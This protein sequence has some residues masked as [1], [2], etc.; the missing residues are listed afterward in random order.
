MEYGFAEESITL[1]MSSIFASL[2]TEGQRRSITEF[3]NEVV[4]NY[5]LGVSALECVNLEFNATFKVTSSSNDCFALRININ[6][7]RSK[8]NLAAEVEFVRYL[9]AHSDIEL[10]NPVARSSGEFF[11]SRFHGDS[12][13]SLNYVLYTW[14]NGEPIGSEPNLDQVR[15]LGVTMAKMH[16]ATEQFQLSPSSSLEVLRDPLWG[17]KDNLTNV[18]SPLDAADKEKFSKTLS[19]I[20]STLAD[21]YSSGTPQ[22][23][24][25]DLHGW[26]VLTH[27]DQL[28]VLDF[29]DC[30]IGY[31]IQDLATTM[32]YLD[33][34]EQDGA[35]LEGYSSIRELPE[36][37]AREMQLL[38]LQRRLVLLN[39]LLETSTP[40]H[41]EMVPKY[42]EETLRR[43]DG[44]SSPF[45]P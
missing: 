13:R 24:H 43:V 44:A 16:N 5:S 9:A 1:E 27:N 21:L 30:A 22:P 12:S 25:A 20:D 14:L 36:Y 18:D 29:D 23:I 8:A 15:A 2:D 10:P 17:Q 41:R 38:L 11:G 7:R 31:P 32:Y 28:A 35:L 33:T 34:E 39:Y 3:A 37:S 40:E 45:R 4:S 6:S 42:L 19:E 26:N